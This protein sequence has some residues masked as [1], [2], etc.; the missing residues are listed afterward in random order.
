MSFAKML[1]GLAIATGCC[2]AGAAPAQ[3][4]PDAVGADPNPF[5]TLRCD[6]PETAPV[7]SAQRSNEIT[8]GIREGLS[9][10][11]PGLPQPRR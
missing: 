7:G 4:D 10:W 2:V 9:A 6:C 1:G 8:Q 3:A 11:V 5:G